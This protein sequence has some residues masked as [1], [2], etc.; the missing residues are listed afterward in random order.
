[1]GIFTKIVE[2]IKRVDEVTLAYSLKVEKMITRNEKSIDENIEILK[3][4]AVEKTEKVIPAIKEQASLVKEIVVE[5]TDEIVEIADS[6]STKVTQR[7]DHAR[8]KTTN[9][10]NSSMSNV[11]NV[12]IRV[13]VDIVSTT[14]VSTVSVA[15]RLIRYICIPSVVETVRKSFRRNSKNQWV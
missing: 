12:S 8:A 3:E 14:V 10:V 6:I 7:V 5:K 2:G 15:Y 4:K 1:M 13:V 11:R 9:V